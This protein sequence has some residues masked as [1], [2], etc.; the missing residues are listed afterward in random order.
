MLA[1][2]REYM[3]LR[4]KKKPRKASSLSPAEVQE[5]RIHSWKRSYR[6]VQ[7]LVSGANLTGQRLLL[8]AE[9]FGGLCAY[10]KAREFQHWDHVIPISRGGKNCLANLRPACKKCNLSKH[11]KTPKEWCALSDWEF[12]M[13]S[14]LRSHLNDAEVAIENKKRELL[15]IDITIGKARAAVDDLK[16]RIKAIEGK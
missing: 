15:E 2:N 9:V 8:R 7:S 1:K 5:L 4:Y 3:R 16:A 13:I 11:A 14:I 10:C 6:E 12:S